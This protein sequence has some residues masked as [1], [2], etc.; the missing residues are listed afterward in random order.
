MNFIKNRK[1]PDYNIHRYCVTCELVYPKEIR[2]C[3]VCHCLLRT[4]PT[5]ARNRKKYQELKTRIS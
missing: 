3:D 4:T 2:K 5:S 1:K